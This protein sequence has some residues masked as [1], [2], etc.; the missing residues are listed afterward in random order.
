M[1]SVPL[2]PPDR[3]PYRS[4]LSPKPGRPLTC[5]LLANEPYG[6][7]CHWESLL[8]RTVPCERRCPYC[9][10]GKKPRWVGYWAAQLRGTFLKHGPGTLFILETSATLCRTIGSCDQEFKRGLGLILKRGDAHNSRVS[11]EIHVPPPNLV[12]PTPFSVAAVL[13]HIWG[14]VRRELE[15]ERFELPDLPPW[16]G[17]ND[18]D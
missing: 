15:E 9:D 1:D 8:G 3:T 5:V 7:L 11:V 17:G 10:E 18:A 16:Q 2:P 14:R 6:V 4:I 12:I 13:D